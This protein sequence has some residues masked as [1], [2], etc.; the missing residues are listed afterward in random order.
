MVDY[1]FTQRNLTFCWWDYLPPMFLVMAHV[2]TAVSFII[3][4]L[5]VGEYPLHPTVMRIY[6][7]IVVVVAIGIIV[8][9]TTFKQSNHVA[10]KTIWLSLPV[11]ASLSL[12]IALWMTPRLGGAPYAPWD[13]GDHDLVN[14]FSLFFTALWILVAVLQHH[15]APLWLLNLLLTAAG[16]WTLYAA[17]STFPT[18]NVVLGWTATVD[19]LPIQVPAHA[20]TWTRPTALFLAILAGT[21][22]LLT[23][24]INCIRRVQ[25]TKTGI[26]TSN[27]FDV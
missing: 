20:W 3:F 17:F 7:T 6:F 19:L 22:V 10:I 14:F 16:G 25:Q 4:K 27:D 15:Q 23:T 5:R 26:K 2:L 21:A 12:H 1:Q 11:L 24:T 8:G 13:P 9:I 18:N